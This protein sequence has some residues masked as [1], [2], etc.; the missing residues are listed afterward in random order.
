MAIALRRDPGRLLPSRR[1]RLTG[2]RGAA[3]REERI[4]TI[5]AALDA[6]ITLLDTGDLY[7]MGHN[8][9]LI[10]DALRGRDRDGVAI[11][12]K[13]GALR[14]P[15]GAWA[16]IDGRP[17]AVRNF[18]AY[19]LRRLDTDH[20]DVYRVARVD[21]DVPIEETIGAIAEL[22]ESGHVRHIGLSWR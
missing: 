13:F 6:G 1:D 14:D 4:A 19:T 16:G 18:M 20:V 17:V 3:D 15:D 11:S 12:V 5:R 9:M 8:E 7:G 22:V 2:E 21:P 10:R